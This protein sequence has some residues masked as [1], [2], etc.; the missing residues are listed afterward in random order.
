MKLLRVLSFI[1][2]IFIGLAASFVFVNSQKTPFEKL[3]AEEMLKT[4]IAQR[5]IAIQKAV[6]EG[7]YRC[8]INP[9]CTMCY[10]Q[11]N[12]WNNYTAGTCACDDAILEGREPCPQ[13]NTGICETNQ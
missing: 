12:Q 4:V 8:C 1:A 10:M 7:N 11:P 9:P 2:S 5:N 13:C 3:G 6:E